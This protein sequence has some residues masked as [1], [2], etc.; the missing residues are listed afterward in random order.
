[1]S[2]VIFG[3]RLKDFEHGSFI[4]AMIHN[5]ANSIYQFIVIDFE[6]KKGEAAT[7][8]ERILLRIEA[9][10]KSAEQF[11]SVL[12][13]TYLR[14]DLQELIS[15]DMKKKDQVR[16]LNGAEISRNEL[17]KLFY[18][19]EENGYTFS[20]F[21]RDAERTSFL[22]KTMPKIIYINEDGNAQHVGETDLSD[23]Q[24]KHLVDERQSLIIWLLE[25]E[26][27]WHCFLQTMKGLKGK[28]SG[29]MG[30]VPHIHYLSNS[31]GISKE[32]LLNKI[33]NEGEYMTTKVHMPL[34]DM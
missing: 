16:L 6:L 28:E 26:D 3:S 30:T 22:D 31:F 32:D 23:G 1:M 17:L 19:A 27:T 12:K 33:K 21:V 4:R 11:Q 18:Y 8:L 14:E 5:H 34:T 29:K 9:L 10:H 25:K 15:S 24:M 13:E 20:F 7:V 2:S